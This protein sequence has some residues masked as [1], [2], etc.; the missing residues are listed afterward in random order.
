MVLA[1][2]DGSLAVTAVNLPF[3]AAG[4]A[5]EPFLR[6]GEQLGRLASSLLGG[7]LR[8]LQVDLWEV[9][10]ELRVPVSIAAVRG[11]LSP[12]MGEAVNF[13]NA[14]KIAEIEAS[15]SCVRPTSRPASIRS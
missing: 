3:R 13:V 9:D 15:R 11:A 5:G 2:L 14:E 4:P 10:E 1:A 6:L 8:K 7:S 12:A